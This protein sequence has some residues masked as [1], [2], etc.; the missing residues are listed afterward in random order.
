MLGIASNS[1]KYIALRRSNP[2]S[3]EA[4]MQMP[5]RLTPGKIAIDWKHPIKKDLNNGMGVLSVLDLEHDNLSKTTKIMPNNMLDMPIIFGASNSFIKSRERYPN[6]TTGIVPKIKGKKCVSDSFFWENNPL[7]ISK[8]SF[9]KNTI[10]VNRLPA[11]SAIF[12]ENEKLLMLKMEEK[13]WRLTEEL[14]GSIS[15]IPWIRLKNNILKSIRI[16]L[17]GA[18]IEDYIANSTK[19]QIRISQ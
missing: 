7:K 8:I 5:R 13:K 4:V 19:D 9:L 11:W 12:N 18:A 17:W 3:L 1:E 14:M 16:T 15:E 2:N 10:S 6:I